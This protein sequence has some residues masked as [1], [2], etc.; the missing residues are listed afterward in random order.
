IAA[1]T[2]RTASWTAD[3]AAIRH[4][5]TLIPG[6]RPLRINIQKFAESSRTKN[7]SVKGA[8]ADPSVQAR[9]AFQVAYADGT[10]MIDSGM[11]RQVHAF[12]GGGVDAPY[13]A[14]AAE[15]VAAWVDRA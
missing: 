1:D 3:I 5:A 8:P 14:A 9:T 15:R 2:V 7:F 10:V 13:D 12:F 4:A 6:R 11:D